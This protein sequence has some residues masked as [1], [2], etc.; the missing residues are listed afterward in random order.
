MYQNAKGSYV[1]YIGLLKTHEQETAPRSLG[2]ELKVC[3][4]RRTSH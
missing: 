2:D 4:F 3:L 1:P